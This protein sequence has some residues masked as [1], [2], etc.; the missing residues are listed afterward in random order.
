V[1]VTELEQVNRISAAALLKPGQILTVPAVKTVA[2]AT[3]EPR[4]EE[5]TSKKPESAPATKAAPVK[6]AVKTHT[7]KKGD[8]VTGIAKTHGVSIA[9]LMK[10]N[11]IKDPKLLQLGQ[12]LKIPGK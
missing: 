7:V 12:S 9:D 5:A 6:S 11:G 3:T 4:R 2:A 8:T 1:T 10:L